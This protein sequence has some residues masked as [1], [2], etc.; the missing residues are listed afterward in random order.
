MR[1]F[2]S[3]LNP[4]KPLSPINPSGGYKI[5]DTPSVGS[6][7]GLQIFIHKCQLVKRLKTEFLIK[8][9]SGFSLIC[10][11][12]DTLDIFGCG[13]SDDRIHQ[14]VPESAS[15][16]LRGNEKFINVNLVT[17]PPKLFSAK[18]SPDDTVAFNDRQTEKSRIIK[19][20]GQVC[21]RSRIGPLIIPGSAVV[22]LDE[23]IGTAFDIV[24]FYFSYH[25]ISLYLN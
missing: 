4:N 15:L 6:H 2:L 21:L 24:M 12:G 19:H 1:N 5:F 10:K 3:I 23:N 9:I 14:F 16:F 18:A 7:R 13:V 20:F 11:Q 25:V 17:T 8:I 22:G